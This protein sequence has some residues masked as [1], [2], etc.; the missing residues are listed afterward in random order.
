MSLS[1]P[2]EDEIKDL[3][4][5]AVVAGESQRRLL[6]RDG[7]FNV[8]REG[9]KVLSSLN[10]YHFLLTIPWW[11]FFGLV[12]ASYLLTNALF[13]AAYAL[14]GPGTLAGPSDPTRGVSGRFLPAFFFSVQTLATIGY[15]Q[16]SPVGL[17]ANLL[18]TFEALVGLLGFALVTGLLFARFSRPTAKI[19]FSKTAVVT[20]YKGIT[21]FEFRIVNA[22]SN[23]IIEL[24][25]KVMFSTMTIR[26]G[27]HSR[28][29]HD[30]TLERRRVVFFPL[31]WTIVHPIEDTSPL[32]G[33]T[34][35]D[36]LDA[37][38]EFLILLTG[39]EE[40]FSQT[41]HAR[42]SYKADEIVWNAKFRN[43]FNPPTDD[44]TL[45]IDIRRLHEIEKEPTL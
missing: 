21:A 4:F 39:I 41:V 35:Q 44:R 2:K 26:D 8:K 33:L 24:E 25:A 45:S 38:A 6:N 31:A 9:G 27:K 10:L 34:H 22:R 20:P 3:G 32:Y 40:T 37:E 15:G 18:V 17:A 13:A 28:Q 12:T 16:I 23:Q 30:L 43:V 36:L 29:F 42:S 11:Q 1:I 5:G 14:C 19:L 7:S